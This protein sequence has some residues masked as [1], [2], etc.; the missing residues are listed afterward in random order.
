MHT[1][2]HLP[3]TEKQKQNSYWG[4][5]L[6]GIRSVLEGFRMTGRHLWQ[7]RQSRTPKG[8]ME[9]GYFDQETGIVTLQYPHEQLPLPDNGRYRL[10]NKIDDCIVCDLCAKICPVNCIT[11]NSIKATEDIGVTADGT[12]KRLFAATFDID[13]AQCCYCGLCT[14]VCPTDCLTMTKVYDFPE[15]DIKNMIYHYTDLTSEQ[16]QDKQRLYEEQ[17]AEIAKAKAAALAARA[18]KTDGASPQS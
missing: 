17:Q 1:P 2:D 11:I 18:P 16:A 6:V 13:M 4:N 7:A 15:A 8:I 10:D 9:P 14:T 3:I 12:K 5:L